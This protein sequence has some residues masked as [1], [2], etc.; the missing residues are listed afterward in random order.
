MT[1]LSETSELNT[2][3]SIPK[4]IGYLQNLVGNEISQS[5]FAI[6]LATEKRGLSSAHQFSNESTMQRCC[7]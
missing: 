4:S 1:D 5:Y 7:L 2:T 3:Q 6:Q